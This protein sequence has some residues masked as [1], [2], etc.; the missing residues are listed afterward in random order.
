LEKE[1]WELAFGEFGIVPQ[2]GLAKRLSIGANYEAVNS[3]F[4]MAF[5]NGYDELTFYVQ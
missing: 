2:M 5:S 1:E 3:L 4:G